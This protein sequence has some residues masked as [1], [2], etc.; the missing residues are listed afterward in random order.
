MQSATVSDSMF[1]T[2]NQE[3]LALAG[4]I[5]LKK[6]RKSGDNILRKHAT[7][8]VAYKNYI[9]GKRIERESVQ[10]L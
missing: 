10:K 5:K 1:F 3:I 7:N 2:S 4:K 9:S 6:M 8:A